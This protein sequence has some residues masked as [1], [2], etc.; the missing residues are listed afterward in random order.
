MII[1]KEELLSNP[2]IQNRIKAWLKDGDTF[3]CPFKFGREYVHQYCSILFDDDFSCRFFSLYNCPCRKL[4]LD[5]VIQKAKEW[6][7]EK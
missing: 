3:R 6:T 1:T 7:E 5:Y 4:G 2:H